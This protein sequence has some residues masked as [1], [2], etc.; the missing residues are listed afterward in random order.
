MLD[1][2]FKLRLEPLA[3]APRVLRVTETPDHPEAAY[4][5]TTKCY[6]RDEGWHVM[7][8]E[9][10]YDAD[11]VEVLGVAEGLEQP[12]STYRGP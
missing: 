11:L 8:E 4:R 12:H 10:L 6:L 9:L 5:L 2:P 3:G 7:G 1:A